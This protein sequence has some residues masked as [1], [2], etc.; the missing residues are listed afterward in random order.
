MQDGSGSAAAA[1]TG[2]TAQ[3]GVSLQELFWQSFDLFTVLLVLGS[4]LAGAV[5]VR[6]VLEIRKGVVLPEESERT[7]RRLIRDQKWPELSAYVERDKSFLSC[8]VKAALEAPG[9]DKESM[10]EAAEIAAGEQAGAWFR[11]IEPLNVIGNMGPLLGLA[12]TVWGM[13]I[14]FASLGQSGGQA[15]PA[16]LSTGISKALFHTLLGLMLAVPALL[17]FGFYRAT[18]DR[19][20][21]RAMALAGELVEM[22]PERK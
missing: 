10:R 16:A 4:V 13:I 20:C 22:L 19:L 2:N 3:G 15:N 17:T 5:I 12:G 21:T 7:L 9:G 11:R 6:C 1:A 14:A 18:V 8:V